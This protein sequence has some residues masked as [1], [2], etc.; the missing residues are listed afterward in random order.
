MEIRFATEQDVGG[1]LELL[2]QVGQL[3]HEGR[4]DLF[5]AGAQK[6]GPSQVLALLNSSKT[7]I[8][9]AV[10]EE[11]VLGY[12][13]CKVKTQEKDPIFCDGTELYIDDICVDENHRR[14]GIARK[15]YDHTLAYAKT[16]GCNFVT[17]HVWNGND[18]AVRFY[19]DMGMTPR[20][21][22]MEI[23]VEE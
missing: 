14:M 6:Y 11:K 10:E 8:F 18:S 12:G 15:L 21:F 9:V 7:P 4:P 20:Y 1:I 5:R 3:H 16:S 13:F 17:L 19:E 22:M 2:R 23:P